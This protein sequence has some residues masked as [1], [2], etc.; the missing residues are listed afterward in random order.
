MVRMKLWKSFHRTYVIIA[1]ACKVN[2][3]KLNSNNQSAVWFSMFSNWWTRFN[4]NIFWYFINNCCCGSN[5]WGSKYEYYSIVF[6][7]VKI[8]H[9]FKKVSVLI[10][11]SNVKSAAQHASRIQS[12]TKV[13][14]L[15]DPLFSHFIAEELSNVLVQ[16]ANNYSH[17]L[18]PSSNLGKNY[19]PRAAALL[20]SS[21][22]SDIIAVQSSDT[23][24]RAMYAGNAIATVKMSNAIKVIT[25]FLWNMT[26]SLISL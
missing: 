6:Y 1:L 17:V 5:W 11:G 7:F 4:S 21:P 16:I 26:I 12:V 3:Q 18:A 19:I 10:I 25:Q 2:F 24:K 13:L 20:D 22:L 14:T 23:F 9:Y 15:E 8:I